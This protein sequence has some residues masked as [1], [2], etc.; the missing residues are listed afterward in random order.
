MK[1]LHQMRRLL[2]FLILDGNVIFMYVDCYIGVHVLDS[3]LET[4]CSFAEYITSFV[5][6]LK[7]HF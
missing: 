3:I 5:N 7:L 6:D 2:L 4:F 1:T